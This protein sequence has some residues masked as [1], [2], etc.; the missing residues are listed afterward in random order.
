MQAFNPNMNILFIFSKILAFL[1]FA[2]FNFK[3]VGLKFDALK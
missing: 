1:I 3:P 2:S